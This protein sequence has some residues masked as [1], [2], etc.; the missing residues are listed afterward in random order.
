MTRPLTAAERKR[1]A[2]LEAQLHA[3]GLGAAE[4]DFTMVKRKVIEPRGLIAGMLRDDYLEAA[5]AFL[6][7]HAFAHP[8]DRAIWALH[9]EGVSNRQIEPRLRQ[10]GAYRY[11]I[12]QTVRRLQAL[13]LRGMPKER[14]KPGRAAVNGRTRECL[15]ITVRLNEEDEGALLHIEEMCRARGKPV[16]P[17]VDIMRLALRAFAREA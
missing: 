10:D 4:F 14:K 3:E 6:D 1:A 16:M 11:R 8:L 17:R 13:M 15:Q 2:E 5:R 9:A 12:D 7:D